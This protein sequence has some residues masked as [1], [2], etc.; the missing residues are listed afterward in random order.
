MTWWTFITKILTAFRAFFPV[1]NVIL[2]LTVIKHF[3][4]CNCGFAYYLSREWMA[5]C[6]TK[7]NVF[8]LLKSIIEI[9][10]V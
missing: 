4:K 3:I 6:A 10:A 1:T 7:V 5:N 2:T 8:P 9:Q